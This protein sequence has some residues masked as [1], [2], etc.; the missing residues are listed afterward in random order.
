MTTFAPAPRHPDLL[1]ALGELPVEPFSEGFL[2]TVELVERYGGDWALEL[3]ERLELTAAL[4]EPAD[5]SELAARR[6]FVPGFVPALDWLLRRLEVDGAIGGAPGGRYRATGALPRPSLAG[7]R[8]EGLADDP[9]IAPTL[10]LLDLAAGLYPALARGEVH[11]ERALF[12]TGQ[13]GLWCEYFDNRNPVYAINNLVTAVAVSHRLPAA[14]AFSL[15]EVGAGAGSGTAAVLDELERSGRLPALARYQVTE[16]GAFFRRRGERVCRARFPGAPLVYG[17]LD[18]NPPLPAEAVAAAGF[19]VVFGVNVLHVARDLPSTIAALAALLAPGG[20]LVAGECI[21]LFPGQPVA[22]ELVFLA[23][24]GFVNVE[25]DRERRPN[26]GFLT[27]EQWLRLF[28]E[29]GLEP[30][31]LVPDLQRIRALYP[32]FHTG[33][34]CGQRPA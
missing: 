22:A 30:V 9:A 11:G 24:E 29:A 14:G 26:P 31:E 8:A 15:L 10:D 19:D 6:G 20:W 4:A 25:L 23:L 18:I 33:A 12:G 7:L 1:D 2:R 5:A 16:P 28:R 17:A 3:G 27:P 32:R 13:I 21:R 34:V